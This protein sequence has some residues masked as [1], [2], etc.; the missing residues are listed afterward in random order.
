MFDF[1]SGIVGAV[2]N[3]VDGLFSE[4]VTVV[5]QARGSSYQVAPDVARPSFDV[6]GYVL[7][8]SDVAANVGGAG[9]ASKFL[10]SMA[11][12]DV[13]LSISTTAML[14]ELRSSDRVML[15]DR[16]NTPVYQVARAVTLTSMRVLLH[17]VR[18]S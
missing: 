8:R 11:E 13:V 6:V 14:C 16:R 17:M 18:V 15:I 10:E 12:T 4:N 2:D 5:P 9:H 1:V 7:T 3:V